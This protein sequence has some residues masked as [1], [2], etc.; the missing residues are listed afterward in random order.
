MGGLEAGPKVATI[1]VLTMSVQTGKG[2][3][4]FGLVGTYQSPPEDTAA[5]LLVVEKARRALAESIPFVFFRPSW[6]SVLQI[7]NCPLGLCD[8]K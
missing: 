2:W 6:K 8:V 3:P 7:L 1:F 5:T 4:S